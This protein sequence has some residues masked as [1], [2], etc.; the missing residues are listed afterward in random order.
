MNGWLALLIAVLTLTSA[1]GIYAWFA[2]M[3]VSAHLAS[4][5]EGLVSARQKDF[6]F[7]TRLC[8][9]MKQM[10]CKEYI[11]VVDLIQKHMDA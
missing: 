10:G 1:G 3:R 9:S 7:M 2:E 11:T 4:R 5:V 8:T 6:Q